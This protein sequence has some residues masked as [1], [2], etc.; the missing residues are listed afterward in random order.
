MAIVGGTLAM[1]S[2]PGHYTRITLSLP[3]GGPTE[4]SATSSHS[5]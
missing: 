4:S 2:L 5:S 3:E 1:E